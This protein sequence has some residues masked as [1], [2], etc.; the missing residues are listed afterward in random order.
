MGFYDRDYYRDPRPRGGFG[1]FS[2]WSVTTWLIVANIVVLFLDGILNR[3]VRASQGPVDINPEDV[4]ALMRYYMGPLTRWGYFST[5]TAIMHGQVWRFITFQFLH[6]GIGHL[7]GNALGM[8]FFGPIIEG[9]FGAR[10]YL[11]FYLLCGFAG[12]VSYLLLSVSHVVISNPDTPLVGA[13]AGVFGLLV[14]AAMIAPDIEI[15]IFIARVPIRI[16]AIF[17]MLLAAYTVFASG[18]GAGGEAAHLGGGV[19]GFLLIKNQHWLN[20]F[21]PGRTSAVSTAARQPR[22]RKRSPF[23]KDWSKDMNR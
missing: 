4:G 23:Q 2:A 1:Y 14:A 22:R 19:L 13:S 20:L 6:A 11:A 17:A 5:T 18:M 10:R 16:L 9:H 8:Y 21:A 7:I 3:A 12:A 15:Y